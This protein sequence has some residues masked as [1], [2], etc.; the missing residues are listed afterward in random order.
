M[1]ETRIHSTRSS[2]IRR[3]LRRWIRNRVSLPA[4][5]E[6]RLEDGKAFTTGRAIIRDI[7]LRGALL[8]RIVLKRPC[9][10]ARPF[11]LVLTFKSK[12]YEGIG[13]MCRPV[14]FGKGQDF[15]LAVEFEDLWAREDHR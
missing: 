13:A 15:E 1:A 5:V 6:V 11:H 4:L 12:V 7:S 14:R 2:E 10:P 3:Y 8:G 9:L